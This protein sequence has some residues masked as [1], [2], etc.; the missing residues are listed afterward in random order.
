MAARFDEI[1]TPSVKQQAMAFLSQ[2]PDDVSWEQLAHEFAIAAGVAESIEEDQIADP[3]Q[4]AALFAKAG[5]RL[6]A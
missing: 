4:V 1:Q 2:L 5:V 3:A 6:A